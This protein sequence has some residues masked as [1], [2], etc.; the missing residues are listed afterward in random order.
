MPNRTR[1]LQIKIVVAIFITAINISVYCIWIPARLQISEEYIHLNDIWDRCEKCIYLVV[2]ATLNWYFIRTVKK[3]LV[4]RGLTKYNQL[5]Q[6][7]IWIVGLSLSM[8]ALIIG[9][10]SL[11]NSFV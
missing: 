1:A 8:D 11:S 7:N 4:V 5:V 9:M 2:D 3:T 6:F 10:M